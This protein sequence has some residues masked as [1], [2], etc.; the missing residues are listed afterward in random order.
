MQERQMYEVRRQKNKTEILKTSIS[1]P[2]KSGGG[3]GSS[4]ASSS[5]EEEEE[6]EGLRI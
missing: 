2:V 5:Q 1:A 4:Y 3:I 6:K